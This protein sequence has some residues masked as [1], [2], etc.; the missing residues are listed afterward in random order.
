MPK[1]LPRLSSAALQLLATFREIPPDDVA[2]IEADAGTVLE[3]ASA[4]CLDFDD[5]VFILTQLGRN[6]ADLYAA[7]VSHAPI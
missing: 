2:T 3:C 5:G 4:H 6:V 7:G 1:T